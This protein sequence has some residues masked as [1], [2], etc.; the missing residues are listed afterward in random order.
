MN[1]YMNSYIRERV[2]VLALAGEALSKSCNTPEDQALGESCERAASDLFMYLR[3][4]EEVGKALFDDEFKPTPSDLKTCAI[5][6]LDLNNRVG[7]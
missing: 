7:D 4:V 2:D 6:I 5:R 3:I 1:L